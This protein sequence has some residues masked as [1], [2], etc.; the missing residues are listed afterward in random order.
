LK[1][2]SKEEVYTVLRGRKDDMRGRRSNKKKILL[3]DSKYNSTTIAKFINYIMLDGQKETATSILY[4][5][6]DIASKNLKRDS[7]EIFQKA[8]E[9]VSPLVE[10]RSRRIGGANYQVPIEVRE[11]RRTTL[12]L[13]WILNAARDKKGAKI[14]EKLAQ[15]LS[16]ACKG[17]GNSVKCREDTHR[18]AEA[19]KAFAHFARLK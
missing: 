11:P 15:E 14:S 6:L 9:N 12:G 5:A 2:E 4:E 7:L 19:N 1:T 17:I 8:L 18:M 3:P 16:D 13:R 10:V